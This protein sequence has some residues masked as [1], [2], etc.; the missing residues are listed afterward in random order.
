MAPRLLCRGASSAL[1]SRLRLS[2]SFLS[3]K[4]MLMPT[5]KT[6]R[7]ALLALSLQLGLG[8][9]ITSAEERTEF[10]QEARQRYDQGR[11]LQKQGQLKEAIRAYEEAIQLGMGAFPR[12]HLQRANSN[13]D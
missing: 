7:T 9:G 2:G 1:L 4:D 5:R 3:G 10:P 12:V 6:L 11:D 8:W 13:L